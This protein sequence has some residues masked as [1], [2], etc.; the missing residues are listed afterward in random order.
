MVKFSLLCGQA[1]GF[2]A[3]FQSNESFEQ[4]KD[5]GQIL[6]PHCASTDVRKALMAPN[7]AS[8]KTR[9]RQNLPNEIS[10]AQSLPAS[11]K[12]NGLPVPTAATEG[13]T[14]PQPVIQS[15]G[16]AKL[17]N[18][19]QMTQMVR[20]MH[21]MVVDNCTNVGSKFADEARK[22]HQGETEAKPIYGTSTAEEREALAD[23]GIPFA[24]LPDLPKDN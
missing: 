24:Q 5:A 15:E 1:H 10:D 19:E 3:W 11:D 13:K 12:A 8:P 17:P 23:E 18:I 4:Q 9:A 14:D 22:M 20:Q 6:C 21:R 16:P 7:L 2:E